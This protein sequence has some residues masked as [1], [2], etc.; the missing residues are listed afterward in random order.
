MPRGQ[1]EPCGECHRPTS[2]CPTT[3]EWLP[4]AGSCERILT[5][6]DVPVAALELGAQGM[7]V[8]PCDPA[9]KQPLVATGFK[10]A[11][12]DPTTITTWWKQWPQAM[13]GVPTGEPS[14]VFVLDIDA[15]RARASTG[16]SRWPPWKR[17][18]GPCRR[19]GRSER[20]AVVNI[21]CFAGRVSRSPTA[22]R[23]W[24]PASISAAMAATSSSRPA[25]TRTCPYEWIRES[26]PVAA[27][28]W[29]LVLLAGPKPGAGADA[30]AAAGKGQECRGI[31]T[32]RRHSQMSAGMSRGLP[33]GSATR[34]STA[35]PS[36]WDN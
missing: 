25:S 12:T 33:T 15:T 30:G 19:H 5:F 2:L 27:P 8:F 21:G 6:A 9:S 18:T 4:K 22:P 23:S 16:L 29:L 11:T 28:P 36:T 10:A 17:R 7:P 20:R 32:Q 34:R 13:I 31:P 26:E 3:T 14:G 1:P 35:L 24:A